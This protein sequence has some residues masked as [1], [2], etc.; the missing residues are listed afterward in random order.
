MVNHAKKIT[1]NNVEC[2]HVE[3]RFGQIHEEMILST[4]L[5]SL[6]WKWQ[7]SFEEGM[8]KSYEYYVNNNCK[9]GD[10]KQEESQSDKTS[11]VS[12]SC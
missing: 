12:T 1:G 8:R 6:G 7:N 2:V 9:W 10:Q 3:D 11:E 4:R 5:Q